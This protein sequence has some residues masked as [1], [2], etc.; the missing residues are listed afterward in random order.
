MK[1]KIVALFLAVSV[2]LALVLPAVAYASSSGTGPD[3]AKI[4]ILSKVGAK[5]PSL[6]GPP[7]SGPRPQAA[8][9][10]LGEPVTGER[11]AIV[12]GISDYPGAQSVLELTSTFCL[13]NVGRYF[14][15]R[16]TLLQVMHVRVE[17][18][19]VT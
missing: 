18:A 16:K 2:L 6:V 4:E 9:G 11:Y 13:C 1:K 5:G 12:I 7:S 14:L 3:A 8:T 19:P 15:G 10:I 17:R